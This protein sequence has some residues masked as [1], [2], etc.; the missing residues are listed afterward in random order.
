MKPEER[1]R[2]LQKLLQVALASPHKGWSLLL[3]VP[4]LPGANVELSRPAKG[5]RLVVGQRWRN[6]ARRPVL[7]SAVAWLT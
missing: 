7:Q 5:L 2:R 3:E 6:E 1:R 4:G